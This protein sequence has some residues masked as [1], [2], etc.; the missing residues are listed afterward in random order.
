[1]HKYILLGFI[2]ISHLSFSQTNDSIRT[3]IDKSFD[4]IET[5]SIN[6]ANIGS[7]KSWLY[8]ESEK[9]TSTDSLAPLYE[10][11]FKRLNDYHGNLKYKGKTYGWQ[12]PL[13]IENTYVKNR[14]KNAKSVVSTVL[15]GEFGYIRIPGNNDFAFKKVDSIASDIVAHINK[16]NATEIKGWIIDLRFNTGG[17]MYPILLGLKDFI[18]DDLVFGGFRNS[19]D[20]PSGKWEIIDSRMLIDGMQLTPTCSVASTIPV[21]VPLVILTSAYTASAGEMAA[22]ALMGRPNTTVIGEKTANYTTAVQGFKINAYAGINLSTDY[23]VDRNNKVYKS[24]IVPDVEVI[25]GDDL[26]NMLKDDKIN[27]ALELFRRQ[28]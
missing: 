5:N 1:M 8:A 26:E 7:I 19:K 13:N 11:V 25:G 15:N 21:T 18:G 2:F 22:I 3:F 9:L 14:L 17:N 10:E 27:K 6:T 24:S 23:V 16:V 28:P 20:E 12:A 4:F